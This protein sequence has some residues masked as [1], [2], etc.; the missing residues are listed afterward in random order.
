MSAVV[1]HLAK[2]DRLSPPITGTVLSVGWFLHQT[3]SN[4]DLLDVP[5]EWKSELTSAEDNK[6]AAIVKE[7][8]IPQMIGKYSSIITLWVSADSRF[9]E[10][11]QVD[12][13]NPLF[14]PCLYPASSFE[15]LP[16][17]YFQIAG[18]DPFRDDDFLYQK[19]LERAGVPTRS[20]LY[21]G[22]PHA[23]FEFDMLDETR[24]FV[25][26]LTKGVQWI[27]AQPVNTKN[28]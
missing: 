6:N 28:A 4:I 16:P 7:S 27:L 17:A 22:V 1:S 5:D 9:I 8:T 23:F 18:Q 25:P 21:P 14:S 11:L 3:K 2:K 24:Q 20:T 19:Q 15:G 26:D 10:W 12:S 13:S